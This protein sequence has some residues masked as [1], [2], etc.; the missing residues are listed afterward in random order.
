MARNACLLVDVD[1]DLPDDPQT[2]NACFID[3]LHRDYSVVGPV[4]LFEGVASFLMATMWITSSRR[5][6]AGLAIL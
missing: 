4:H 3:D 2:R 6:H 1:T 5:G